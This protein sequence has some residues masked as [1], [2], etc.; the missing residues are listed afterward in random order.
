MHINPT[1]T[2]KRFPG[3]MMR[4]ALL[5]LK[6]FGTLMVMLVIPP[7]CVDGSLDNTVGHANA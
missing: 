1:Q 3:F 5:T 7:A 6:N 2:K 4:Q